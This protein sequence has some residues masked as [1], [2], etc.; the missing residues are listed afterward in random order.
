[1]AAF[2]GAGGALQAARNPAARTKNGG[3]RVIWVF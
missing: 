2:C 1:V 3:G